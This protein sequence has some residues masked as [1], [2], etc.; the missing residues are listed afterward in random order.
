MN[1]PVTVKINCPHCG[2][3]NKELFEFNPTLRYCNS[4][5]GGCDSPYVLKSNRETTKTAGKYVETITSTSHKIEGLEEKSVNSFFGEGYWEI[6]LVIQ[7]KRNDGQTTAFDFQVCLK[8]Q[9]KELRETL[10]ETSKG[11]L[12][13]SVWTEFQAFVPSVSKDKKE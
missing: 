3:E 13:Y 4:E 5:E 10:K 6:F 12:G 11:T 2:F 1:K 9:L 8:S 7:S